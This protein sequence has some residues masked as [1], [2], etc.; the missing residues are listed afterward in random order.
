M[1]VVGDVVCMCVGCVCG[2]CGYVGKSLPCVLCV[3][4][5]VRL[6]CLGL[7]LLCGCECVWCV[8]VFVR[9]ICVSM[10][11]VSGLVGVV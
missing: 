9:F 8:C 3:C 2:L 4:G 1:T 11:C 10:V 7:C 5:W 6:V